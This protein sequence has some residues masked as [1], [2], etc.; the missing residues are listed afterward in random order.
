MSQ[1]QY[2]GITTKTDSIDGINLHW[3]PGQTR[4]VSAEVAERL[5]AYP[6]TWKLA[7]GPALAGPEPVHLAPPVREAEEP[8][9]AV[10]FHAMDKDAMIRY[11]EQ[12]YGERLSRRLSEK[13]I[14]HR[15]I[16]L[17][18]QREMEQD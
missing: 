14:R 6:D 7:P 13:N 11:A 8:L 3:Q 18:T 2:I 15:L 1:V 10:D 4:S 9:P 12:H 16:G 17:F 5:L